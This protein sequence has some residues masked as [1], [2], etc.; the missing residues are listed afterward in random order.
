M[1]YRARFIV[2]IIILVAAAGYV[3]CH[4]IFGWPQQIFDAMRCHKA[5]FNGC[6]FCTRRFQNFSVQGASLGS[7]AAVSDFAEVGTHSNRYM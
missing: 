6:I 5:S 3:I 4:S 2:I 7:A 1:R